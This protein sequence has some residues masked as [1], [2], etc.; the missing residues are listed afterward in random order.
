MTT[1]R[2]T[3]TEVPPGLLHFVKQCKK[4]LGAIT[5]DAS[6]QLVASDGQCFKG[7]QLYVTEDLEHIP[8]PWLSSNCADVPGL[9]TVIRAPEI[10]VTNI[11]VPVGTTNRIR[12]EG[13]HLMG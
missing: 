12:E 1:A 10:G 3:H 2:G 11:D 4:V 5:P 13:L 8:F 7:R 9:G 6:A